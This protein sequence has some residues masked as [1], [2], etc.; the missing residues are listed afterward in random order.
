MTTLR[1]FQTEIE[2]IHDREMAKQRARI[3]TSPVEKEEKETMDQK[4]AT[5]TQAK[6]KYN[7]TPISTK[8]AVGVGPTRASLLELEDKILVWTVT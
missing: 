1:T 6:N 4:L 3:V 8:Y 2:E 7:G 5:V